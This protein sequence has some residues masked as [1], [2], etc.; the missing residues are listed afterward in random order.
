MQ[1][2]VKPVRYALG[3]FERLLPAPTGLVSVEDMDQAIATRFREQE[4]GPERGSAP[5]GARW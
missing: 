3:D 2:G 4:A 1:M 5:L